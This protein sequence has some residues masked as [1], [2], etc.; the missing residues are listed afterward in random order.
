MSVVCST[1]GHFTVFGNGFR[2]HLVFV[3]LFW[4]FK[5]LR[6]KEAILNVFWFTIKKVKNVFC[7]YIMEVHQV[8][9]HRPLT[10]YRVSTL[11][12]DLTDR[13]AGHPITDRQA[14]HPITGTLHHHTITKCSRLTVKEFGSTLLCICM[15]STAGNQGITLQRD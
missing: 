13:Q 10:V 3:S 12:T 11:D 4:P 1:G 6:I 5:S 2:S 8:K 9:N 14:G 15:G 7:N